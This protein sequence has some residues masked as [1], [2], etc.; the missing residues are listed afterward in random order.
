[1]GESISRTG[2]L[3]PGSWIN[4]LGASRH[5]DNTRSENI[6]IIMV[7]TL[8]TGE[9][10]S[11]MS[12]KQR[13]EGGSSEEQ[14]TCFSIPSVSRRSGRVI[15]NKRS[16]RTSISSSTTSSSSSNSINSRTSARVNIIFPD[17]QQ[18]FASL[19]RLYLERRGA[20]V[21]L[22]GES[23]VAGRCSRH[24]VLLP[25]NENQRNGLGTWLS[26]MARAASRRSSNLV[27]VVEERGEWRKTD[28]WLHKLP[29][30]K[31]SVLWVHDYQEA[32]VQRIVETLILDE[33]VIEE[34]EE[35]IAEELDITEEEEDITTSENICS[36]SETRGGQELWGTIRRTF[37]RKRTISEDSGYSSS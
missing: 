26:E 36:K 17:G 14:L 29:V 11:V 22:M 33:E 13:L 16:N 27:A 34:E 20:S 12:L 2:G 6:C 37:L 30:I 18:H 28:P 7:T 9:G 21:S 31:E 25:V 35:D 19:L 24:L 8:S 4:L 32:C 1:M 5:T 10:R 3:S 23:L 15:S